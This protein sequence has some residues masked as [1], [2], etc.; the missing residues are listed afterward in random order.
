MHLHVDIKTIIGTLK[1]ITI[2]IA[3][4]I[5]CFF[6]YNR[7]PLVSVILPT[8]N[9][10]DFIA[11]AIESVLS[12]TYP[13][14]EL[15]IIDD[16]STDNS[17][18]I[19][20]QYAIK[21]NRI[22]AYSLKKNSGV[23]IARNTGL[24]VARGKYIAFMDSDDTAYP[25]WLKTAVNFMEKNPQATTGFTNAQLYHWTGSHTQTKSPFSAFFPLYRLAILS[26][27]HVGSIIRHDFIKEHQ[28]RF[29]PSYIA[30]ED[31][32]FHV[33]IMKK[34]GRIE[35]ILPAIPIVLARSHYT[36]KRNYYAAGPRNMNIIR[37]KIYQG[38]NLTTKNPST[39]DMLKTFIHTYP[40]AFNE[41]TQQA[42][43]AQYCHQKNKDSLTFKHP[44]WR[45][46]ILLDLKN[47]RLCRI[48]TGTE[49]AQI[50]NILPNGFSVHWEASNTDETFIRQNQ[51]YILQSE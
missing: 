4:G 7:P 11:E 17:I 24:S 16:G 13:H 42:G 51:I 46:E 5:F 33:Q 34:G 15:I 47:K 10:A 19:I 3:C 18:P 14:F 20:H 41:F 22:R 43:I 26:M 28:I 29:N 32:D 48:S 38:T 21:D 37:E 49:C 25:Y 35:R 27:A 31:W 30:A 44:H 6:S 50:K 40:N 23:S 39:C 2:F 9:R 45:D 12:Q 8:Y 36:N 1:F